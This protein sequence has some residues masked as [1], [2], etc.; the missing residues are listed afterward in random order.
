MRLMILVG[1][2][3]LV[4]LAAFAVTPTTVFASANS[5]GT[6]ETAD[7][8]AIRCSAVAADALATSLDEAAAIEKSRQYFAEAKTA[9]DADDGK[10]WGRPL[11]GPMIFLD[12]ETRTLYANQ[13]DQEHRL[14]N[15]DGVYIGK[16]GPEFP[17]ANTSHRFG[18]VDWTVIPFGNM[19]SSRVD[20]ARLMMHESFHRI[21]NEVGLPAG[22]ARNAHL[23]EKDGR[24]W[25]RLEW[26]AL[27]TA[28]VSWGDERLQAIRDALTFR[29]YRRTLYPDA[30]REEDRMEVH[31]GLAEY[32]GIALN[33]LDNQGNRW[34]MAGRLKVN[35]L[36]PSYPYSFAY[37]TGPA[38]GLLLDMEGEGWR[39]GLT[40]ASSL[41]GLLARAI[42][43]EAPQSLEAKALERANAYRPA[44]IFAGED[45]RARERE[46]A[47]TEYRKLLVTGPVLELP[48]AQLHFTFDPNAVVP[49]GEDGNV[50]P[51]STI[52]DAWGTIEVRKGARINATFTAA[53]VRAPT[54][55]DP[56][57]GDG[58]KLTLKK[59]WQ[60]VPG[61][62]PGS[63]KIVKQ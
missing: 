10:V 30:A 41:S 60:V 14:T 9:S 26:R 19:P 43:F 31:E 57:S 50:Y 39:K 27:S 15:K 44:D 3:L 40:P 12:A 11:Y 49:L 36:R 17:V 16:V 2:I 42:H 58:W 23:D 46:R 61:E 47:V 22:Q 28:L 20:R 62:K 21:Q 4:A 37:E 8:E 32:T 1:P 52:S 25:I 24:I 5:N 34:F 51:T 59:G 33:G 56:L 35:A 55:A 45:R 6:S 7:G 53:Y 54:S 48:L 13:P 18:G 63:F 29:A 38:Y